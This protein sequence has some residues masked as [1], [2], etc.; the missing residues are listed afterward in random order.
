MNALLI[1]ELLDRW[2][3]ELVV[4]IRNE[5]LG[6]V[7]A[8]DKAA[9]L[10]YCITELEKVLEEMNTEAGSSTNENGLGIVETAQTA[11]TS[12]PSK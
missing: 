8:A 3:F 2:R 4:L 6:S 1:D 11:D 7:S 5:E 9:Q 10:K 12:T